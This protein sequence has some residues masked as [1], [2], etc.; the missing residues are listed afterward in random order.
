MTD[1]LKVLL[2]DDD[3]FFSSIIANSFRK[4]GFEVSAAKT[5]DSG[6]E[7]ARAEHPDL[8]LL[9]LTL[10]HMD[11]H[12]VLATLKADPDTKHVPVAILS[13]L[14]DE[15]NKTRAKQGGAVDYFVKMQYTPEQLVGQVQRLLAK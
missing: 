2:I 9:D 10:S 8:I 3:A 12:T 13:S 7:T 14:S 11:G 6:V 4:H 1:Q 5:G 15:D